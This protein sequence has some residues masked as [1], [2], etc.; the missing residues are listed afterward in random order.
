MGRIDLYQRSHDWMATREGEKGEW[1]SGRTIEE[2]IKK[3]HRS[4][5][6][7]VGAEVIYK[8]TD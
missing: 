5:P 4:F 1:E 6:D 8:G 2:A 7:L 3:L